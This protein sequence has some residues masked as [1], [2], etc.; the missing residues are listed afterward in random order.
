MHPIIIPK[1]IKQI[2]T[3]LKAERDSNT[4]KIGNFISHF[5]QWIDHSDRKSIRKHWT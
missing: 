5:Q 2:L 1:Y 4:I 3:D